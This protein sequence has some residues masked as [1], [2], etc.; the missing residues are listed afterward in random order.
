M[1]LTK[2]KLTLEVILKPKLWYRTFPTNKIFD[3]WL[4]NKLEEGAN[5]SYICPHGFT[6]YISEQ[7]IWMRN[8][9]Y[10]DVTLDSNVSVSASRTTALRFRKLYK[11]HFEQELTET[12]KKDLN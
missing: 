2:L 3:D 1:N 10:S 6:V 5:L 12:L 4:W 7:E 9:P 11:K 8:A